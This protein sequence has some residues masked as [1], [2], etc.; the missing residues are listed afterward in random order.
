MLKDSLGN[1]QFDVIENRKSII[2]STL[3]EPQC[4]ASTG[5]VPA[6]ARY[7]QGGLDLILHLMIDVRVHVICACQSFAFAKLEK[8]RKWRESASKESQ[9]SSCSSSQ[10]SIRHWCKMCNR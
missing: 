7:C 10:L 6:R 5:L 2:G 9:I 3:T 1:H 4:R 8:L